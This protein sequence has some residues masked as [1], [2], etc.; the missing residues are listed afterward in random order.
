MDLVRVRRRYL[1]VVLGKRFA[2]RDAFVGSAR[3]QPQRPV[4]EQELSHAV[5]ARGGN[6][7]V[8]REAELDRVLVVGV[9]EPLEGGPEIGLLAL[10]SGSDGIRSYK[11]A[12]VRLPTTPS[13]ASG[14]FASSSIWYSNPMADPVLF[15][16]SVTKYLTPLFA[17][18]DNLKSNWN[19]NEPYS[20]LVTISP[21]FADSAPPDGSTLSS[22]SFI[23]QPL[24][25]K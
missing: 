17:P 15:S 23:C 24:G 7:H 16:F 12:S 8:A 10:G 6:D 14:C 2:D 20:L 4:A 21:P 13:L 18:G 1:V 5:G 3:R 22:P 11:E 19:I 9:A 25:G